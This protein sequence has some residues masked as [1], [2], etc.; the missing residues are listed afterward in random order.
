MLP[1]STLSRYGEIEPAAWTFRINQHGRPE[2]GNPDAPA[3]L[4]FNS[5]TSGMIALLVHD[6]ADG[7]LDVEC[8]RRL[9]DFSG[10]ARLALT[11]AGAAR[12][13]PGQQEGL[14]S[15]RGS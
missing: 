3:G 6:H 4:R 10:V 9:D 14:S 7:G 2:I 13:W 12:L 15:G 11:G 8:L 5:H 1:R